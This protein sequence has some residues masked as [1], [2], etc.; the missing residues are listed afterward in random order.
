MNHYMQNDSLLVASANRF[1]LLGASNLTLSLRLIIQ[2]MQH[3]FGGPSEIL[4]A[5]GHGRS[6]GQFSQVL[7]RGLPGITCCGL[8]QQLESA[9]TQPTYAL[10]TDIGNDIPYEYTPQQIL[11]W[12][13]RCAE[14]LNKHAAQI[15]MTNIPIQSIECLPEWRYKLLRNMLFPFCR[16]SKSEMVKR[17]R[18]VHQ[19]LIEMAASKQFMLCEQ[20]P[21]WF[22]IDG[23]HVSYW[24]RE[25]LYQ[26]VLQQFP[27]ADEK[28]GGIGGGV[29]FF[30]TWKQ[31]PKFAYETLFGRARHCQQP[32]GKL[33]DNT[34]IS[35]Y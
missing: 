30:F 25:A 29:S 10:L 11:A 6:Y 33:A 9:N 1:V 8:W 21:E 7:I 20:D 34:T 31:R 3:R 26:H 28:Q 14:Q 22:G 24:K 12:V 16:L 4:V 17:A 27:V 32:S 15:V 18:I 2:L 35:L 5:A 23:I 13:G 19:G